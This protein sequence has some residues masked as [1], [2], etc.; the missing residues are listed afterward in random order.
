[1]ETKRYDV[2]VV[3]G[4]TA[5]IAAAVAAA[6]R[7]CKTVLIEKQ[8]I[9]GGLATSGLVYVYLPICDGRGTQVSRSLAEELLH[10]SIVYGPGKVDECWR[11]HACHDRDSQR[12]RTV[13]SPA[14]CVLGW[15]EL[16]QEAGV[17]I[18]Y[19]TLVCA[20][21]KRAQR[22]THVEVENTSGRIAVAGK[23]FV[24]ASGDCSVLRMAGAP[25][26]AGQNGQ[27]IWAIEYREGFANDPRE[28]AYYIGRN[29]RMS[30]SSSLPPENAGEEDVR[31]MSY[32]EPKGKDVSRFAVK[33]RGE[34]REMYKK[35][36]ASGKFDRR[37]L[38]PMLLPTMPQFRRI[39][40]IR[41]R[42]NLRPD[43]F[44]VR[45]A[46][47]V[48][49][50]ADWRRSGQVWEVPYGSMLPLNV[51]GV[52][53]AGRCI[54]SEGDAWEVTRVIPAAAVTGEAAGVAASLACERRIAPSALSLRVLQKALSGSGIPLHLDD[55][56]LAYREAP[57]R[58]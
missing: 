55:V 47:S 1:M 49:L 29:M 8:Y 27:G 54:A 24:D 11:D 30:W 37:T 31:Q 4:G 9:P 13:F 41:G 3:G 2:V 45:F 5:G 38:F 14:A 19:D 53:A 10:R 39:Y 6:R 32:R 20:V 23:V 33:T 42:E 12:F 25:V 34:L 58:R 52:I 57:K 15:E 46:D 56:G 22:V 26:S 51:E 43:D 17:D 18:W 35:E 44:G 21:R 48:G 40:C 50:V 36:Y 28:T 16:M 7:G